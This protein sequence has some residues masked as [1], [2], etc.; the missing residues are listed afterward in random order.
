MPALGLLRPDALRLPEGGKRLPRSAGHQHE[1][2][3]HIRRSHRAPGDPVFFPKDA[4]V[5]HVGIY[6]DHDRIWHAPCPGARVRLERIWSGSIRYGRAAWP[7]SPRT[8]RMPDVRHRHSLI[9]G[10][11]HSHVRRPERAAPACECAG[12]VVQ[13]EEAL[14]KQHRKA[15][16]PRMPFGAMNSGQYGYGR[17]L[18]TAHS[19][20]YF[21][22]S[23]AILITRAP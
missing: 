12:A 19:A 17:T 18:A 4:T 10:S 1:H 15:R 23:E 2:T 16:A 8:V 11:L 6:A 22:R 14:F 9:G 21:R 13:H 20:C 3:H 7:A 5:V